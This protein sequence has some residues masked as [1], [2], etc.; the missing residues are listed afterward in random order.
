MTVTSTPP[1]T[2]SRR[3]VAVL[4][5]ES[6]PLRTREDVKVVFPQ[7]VRLQLVRWTDQPQHG[8]ERDQLPPERGH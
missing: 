2:F 5:K 4:Q 6:R 8:H 7:L 3:V 1:R